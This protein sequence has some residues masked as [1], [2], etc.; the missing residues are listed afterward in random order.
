MAIVSEVW[1]MRNC[2]VLPH[3]GGKN[4]I[5]EPHVDFTITPY[6]IV[7]DEPLNG[8]YTI[9]GTYELAP[10]LNSSEVKSLSQLQALGIKGISGLQDVSITFGDT[11]KSN[12]NVVI[13]PIR[14][15]TSTRFAWLLSVNVERDSDT[16]DQLPANLVSI[17]NYLDLPLNKEWYPVRWEGAELI[18][19][20]QGLEAALAGFIR[21]PVDGKAKLI[22]EGLLPF[23]Q[24]LSAGDYLLDLSAPNY[25]SRTIPDDGRSIVRVGRARDSHTLILDIEVMLWR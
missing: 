22:S 2:L 3:E 20:E 7:F 4:I 19:I 11:N 13:S 12:T 15:T 24:P 21:Y 23:T 6:F 5:V 1:F 16:P 8:E 14:T 9:T 25:L 10:M 17:T 18:F